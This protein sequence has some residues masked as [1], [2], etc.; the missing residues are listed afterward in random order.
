MDRSQH[1]SAAQELMRLGGLG[2][3]GGT[4]E[5]GVTAPVTLGHQNNISTQKA[6]YFIFDPISLVT[7][8]VEGFR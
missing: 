5:G 2:L 8:V 7:R 1:E 4:E 6:S 3:M